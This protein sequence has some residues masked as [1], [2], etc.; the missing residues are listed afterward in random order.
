MSDSDSGCRG[1]NPCRSW[2]RRRRE[3]RFRSLFSPSFCTGTSSRRY[4]IQ[5]A[6]LRPKTRSGLEDMRVG[7]QGGPHT[8][9]LAFS[10]LLFFRRNLFFAFQNDRFPDQTFAFER[11]CPPVGKFFAAR[12][13]SGLS[14]PTPTHSIL[15][16]S[17]ETGEPLVALRSSVEPRASTGDRAS[18]VSAGCRAAHR[19]ARLPDPLPSARSVASASSPPRS[20]A[21]RSPSRPPSRPP[22]TPTEA[23][24]S[25]LR[26][27]PREGPSSWPPAMV[28]P[29][30]RC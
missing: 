11:E 2:A 3:P 25:R 29:R 16:W 24:S 18:C 5:R 10:F 28:P 23:R 13:R 17:R 6:L 30:R 12:S 20:T 1:S 15:D 26:P 14:S 22:R 7:V 8:L 4:R 9:I 21:A 19:D 27:L